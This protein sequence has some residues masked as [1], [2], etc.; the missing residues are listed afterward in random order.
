MQSW[1]ISSVCGGPVE[2][3]YLRNASIN[4]VNG[5]IG[6][7]FSCDGSHYIDHKTFF[8]KLESFGRPSSEFAAS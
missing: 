6:M 3:I 1:P 2:T 5:M 7:T 8:D 4:L